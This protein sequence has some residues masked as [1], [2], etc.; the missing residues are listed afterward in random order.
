MGKE[1]MM[2]ARAENDREQG[3][4]LMAALMVIVMLVLM[5]MALL[6]LAGQDAPSIS[7]IIE[8]T[9]AQHLAEG[10]GDLLVSW[11]HEPSA[12]PSSLSALLTKRQDTGAGPSFFDAAGRSQFSGTSDRPDI[13]LDASNDSDAR[14]LNGSTTGF[15]GPLSELGRLERLKMY[16]PMQ[17]GLLGTV[18]VSASPQGRRSLAS[19]IR[20]QL[21]AVNL[22]AIRAAVETG[23]G[24]GTPTPGGGSAILVHWGDLRVMG[25]LVINRIKDLVIKNG[26]API[27]GQSYEAA[28]IMEDRWVQYWIGGEVSLLSPSAAETAGFPASVHAH[29]QPTPG[30]RLDRWDY[31]VL[32]KT[33]QRHGTYYRLDREGRLHSL[34]AAE[35]DPGRLPADVLAS[36]A[37]GQS[38]GLVFIDTLDGEAPRLD[39]LGTL[40]LET[41]Y[42]EAVL[43]V[44]GHVVLK[45]SATGRSFSV[46][47]P[48]PEGTTA[49]GSRIPVTLSGIHLNGLL[50]AAGNV[51]VAREGRMYG[52]IV[53][54]GTIA[55]GPLLEVWY[56]ADFGKGLFRGLPVVYRAPSTWQVKY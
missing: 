32:K 22:P 5:S 47:S 35:S 18:E 6:H 46:L 9:Q 21:G 42:V 20:L 31:D 3:H 27:T 52:A 44:Q 8:Q 2:M 13:L 51:T 19:T 12:A 17:L 41:E 24:L 10:A 40:T 11:F 56:N 43:V 15:T 29:Q 7:A 23:Q 55:T 33:A 49:L 1:V 36:S 28:K 53:V 26:T 50:Y 14:L 16:A 45:P 38:H 37:V 54:G 4:V 30:V 39:N 34:G 48:A 25:D